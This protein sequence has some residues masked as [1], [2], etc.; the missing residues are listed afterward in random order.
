MNQPNPFSELTILE[1]RVTLLINQHNQLKEELKLLREENTNLK[2][3]LAEKDEEINNFQKTIKISKIV[4]NAVANKFETTELKRTIN[5][6]IK[7]IDKCI[8]HLSQ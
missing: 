3:V 4:D 1:R 5:E 6:Y 7:E 8:A 2:A